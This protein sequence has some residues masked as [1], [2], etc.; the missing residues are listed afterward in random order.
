MQ[1]GPRAVDLGSSGATSLIHDLSPSIT[2]FADTAALIRQLDLVITVDTAV[3]HLAGALGHPA[4]VLLPYTPDWRWLGSREDS[5]WYPSLRL[6]RQKTPRDW[7]A[8]ICDVTAAVT[9]FASKRR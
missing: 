8:I 1:I 5:P 7:Q 2:D 9:E 4:F 6:F 3:A